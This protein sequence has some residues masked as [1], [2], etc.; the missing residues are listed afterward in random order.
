MLGLAV[1]LFAIQA[2]GKDDFNRWYASED[3]DRLSHWQQRIAAS[4]VISEANELVDQWLMQ[5][6]ELVLT[7]PPVLQSVTTD[8]VNSVKKTTLVKSQCRIA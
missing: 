1:S 5:A 3:A 8:L 6:E 4:V 7:L 2:L